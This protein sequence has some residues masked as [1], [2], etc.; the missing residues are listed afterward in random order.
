MPLGL[1]PVAMLLGSGAL[2]GIMLGLIGGGGSILAVPLLVYLVGVPSAHGA[3]GTAAVAVALNAASGLATHARL[4][5]VKWRCAMVFTAAG[6]AGAFAGAALGKRLEGAEL[7]AM[8][9]VLMVGVGTYMLTV[10]PKASGQDVRL[11]PESAAYL[12]PRLLLFGSGVGLL[13]GFFGIGGGFLIVPGLVLA[14]GMA[15][16]NAIGTSLF[17]VTAF[18]LA[19]ATSYALS[20][21]V[22]WRL[23][24]LVIV[25]GIAGTLLGTR[26]NAHLAGHKG[27]LAGTFAS[28]VIAVGLYIVASE[29]LKLMPVG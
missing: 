7:L 28:V 8:F 5:T 13:S 10:R 18:G 15:L 19:T 25:G 1:V 3:I 17:A 14:T 26:V 4:G 11:T 6:V 16:Q 27:A 20:G 24:V 2:V 21:F 23:A 12:L 22:D 9:G 29:L